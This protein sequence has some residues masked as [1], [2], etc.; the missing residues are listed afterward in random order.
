MKNKPREKAKDRYETRYETRDK[1]AKK[2]K[3]IQT[4]FDV[5]NNISEIARRTELSRSTVR[6]TL[7]KE[8]VYGKPL[9]SG[10]DAPLEHKEAELPEKGKVKRFILTSAQNNTYINNEFWKS[11]K[12][13]AKY[14]DAEIHVSRYTYNK[15]HY[16]A[17][18]PKPGSDFS[19]SKHNNDLDNDELNELWYD[20]ALRDYT[21]DE[22]IEIAPGLVWCGEMNILPTAVRPISGLETYTGS[23]STV[24]PHAK[25]AVQSVASG[26]FEGTKLI[27]TTGTVTKYNYIAKKAGLKAEFHHVYGALLVEVDSDGDW[28]CRH[29][30]A[31]DTGSFY[32]LDIK[33]NGKKITK[34]HRPEA[35]V[36][37][38]VH[39]AKTDPAINELAWGQGNMLD[40]LKPKKQ[41]L[42]DLFDMNS[43]SHHIIKDSHKMYQRYVEKED[44][45]EYEIGDVADFLHNAVRPWLETI[46]VDSNHDNHLERWLREADY[47]KDPVNAKFFLKAQYKKYDAIENRDKD[48]H[49]IEWATKELGGPDVKF[50]REDESYIICKE[51]GGGIECGIHGHLGTNGSRGSTVGLTKIGRRINKGHDHTAAIMDGVYSTGVMGKLDMDYN[52]G[53]SSWSHTNIITYP[54]GKRTLVTIWNGKWRA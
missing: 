18:T 9:A 39:V 16:M 29:I 23:K 38:D 53:P 7:R 36:W 44:S 35:I 3:I 2:E 46:V 40:E 48:F 6:N 11:L 12:T 51:H 26:K 49:L 34:N 20:T 45:V 17:A 5:G 47:R 42:H 8:G 25:V 33:V 15:N 50:L 27:Y 21:S 28:F 24:F 22:R 31:D 32:D 19:T 41:F 10:K 4:Y 13:F 54:N 1:D 14:M 37:G 52:K 43:R 30:I